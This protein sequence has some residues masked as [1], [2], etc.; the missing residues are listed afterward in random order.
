MSLGER[1]IVTPE[2]TEFIH[3]VLRIGFFPG[4]SQALIDKAV[5]YPLIAML[6][7]GALAGPSPPP[8]TAPNQPSPSVIFLAK[9]G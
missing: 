9:D 8:P 7:G 3:Q 5:H 2:A 4:K 6:L 1:V